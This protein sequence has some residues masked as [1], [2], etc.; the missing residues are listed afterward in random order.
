MV[1]EL[2]GLGAVRPPLAPHLD[3]LRDHVAGALHHHGVADADVLGLDVVLVVQG[4]VAHHDAAHGHRLERGD[5]GQRAGAPDLDPD[6]LDHG[7]G[8]LG[9]ELL[10]DRPARRAADVA[11]PALPVEPVDLDHDAIDLV[12]QLESLVSAILA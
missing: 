6:R 1:G 8:L 11:E 7:L 2:V 9:R 5:R 4:R 3:D 12:R 10:G